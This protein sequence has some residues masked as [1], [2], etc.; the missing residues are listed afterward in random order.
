MGHSRYSSNEIG[1]RGREIYEEQLRDKLEP[2]H[3]GKF[4]VI[5]IETGEYE[6]DEGDLT[7]S[8]RA[9]RKKPDGAR[10]GMRIGYETSGTI[11]NA[12]AEI[13]R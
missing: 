10:F 5:D 9:Y 13:V 7:A 12:M 11:G 3:I 6:M 1:T 8:M 2:E 4:I